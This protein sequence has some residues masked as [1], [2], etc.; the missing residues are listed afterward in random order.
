MPA[1][2]APDVREQGA[3]DIC[4]FAHCAL[5][6]NA[7][8]AVFFT[9]VSVLPLLSVTRGSQADT[10]LFCTELHCDPAGQQAPT[11]TALAVHEAAGIPQHFISSILTPF[12]FGSHP[13]P[14]AFHCVNQPVN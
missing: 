4:L 7:S 8:P 13:V 1:E 5:L 14:V 3:I 11:G 10:H 9:V 12:W 2:T 6:E